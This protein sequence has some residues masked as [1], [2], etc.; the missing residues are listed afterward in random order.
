MLLFQEPH[1]IFTP[2][3]DKLINLVI[4]VGI[5]VFLLRKPMMAFFANRSSEIQ[6]NLKKAER[7]KQEALAQLKVVEE[8]L[9]K[10]DTEIG[11][12]KSQA[13][14]E[15]EAEYQRILSGAQEDA[16][17]LRE[18]ARREI[19][20]LV[21]SARLDLKV[22]AAEQAVSIAEGLIKHEMREDDAHRIVND[23]ISELEGKR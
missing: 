17:K 3:I 10:L 20:G 23:Y 9:N 6:D 15:A 12:I 5:L 13:A 22:Y 19:Q 4:Y 7:E 21:K 16:V 14:H 2:F 11:E 18:T 1:A 8:R